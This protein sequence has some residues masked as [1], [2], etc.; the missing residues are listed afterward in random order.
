MEKQKTVAKVMRRPFLYLTFFLIAVIL[1]ADFL[2]W[3]LPFHR[4]QLSDWSN[5]PSTLEGTVKRK[6][7]SRKNERYIVEL[8][9]VHC[10]GMTR[11]TSE[12]IL[13]TTLFPSKLE[14][15]DHVVF[16][17]KLNPFEENTND[18]LF[19]PKKF[20]RSHDLTLR[21]MI[22]EENL[23]SRQSE[24][25]LSDR[26]RSRFRNHVV[27]TAES[28]LSFEDVSLIQS[29]LLA[30]DSL[31]DEE[32]RNGFRRLGLAHLLCVSGLHVGIL[33]A[34]VL[35]IMK[36]FGI[37]PRISYPLTGGILVLYAF[38]LNFPTPVLRATLMAILYLVAF[39]IREPYDMENACWFSA[40]V[41]LLFRPYQ[42]YAVGFQLSFAATL[43]IAYLYRPLRE[44]CY[45]LKALKGPIALLLAVQA[46]TF[47]LA[48]YYFNYFNPW[49]WLANL[50]FTPFFTGILWLAF[51]GVFVGFFSSAAIL[52][53]G[54]FLHLSLKMFTAFL[55]ILEEI[56]VGA[57]Y[58]ASPTPY[59]FLLYYGFLGLFFVFRRRH[60][61]DVTMAIVAILFLILLL[62]EQG[63]LYIQER[64][65]L[66]VTIIDIGQGDAILIE[67]G[68]KNVLL[69]T[70]G[71]PFSKDAIPRA[72]TVP[73]LKKRGIDRLDALFLSHYDEDHAAG[74]PAL[75]ENFRIDFCLV[76]Y[77]SESKY[78]KLLR[79][80]EIPIEI[81]VEGTEWKLA[82]H[83]SIRCLGPDGTRLP[84]ELR[85]GNVSS[86]LVLEHFD[87]KMLFT[88]DMEREQEL[89]VVGL[90]PDVDVLKVG[91][92][93][94]K[95]ST[96]KELLEASEPEIAV[97]SVGRE[98]PYGHPSEEVL[99][100]LRD[101]NIRVLRTDQSGEIILRFH[102]ESIVISDVHSR[103]GMDIM[104]ILLTL[105]FLG[106]LIF[107]GKIYSRLKEES[108]GL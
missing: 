95:T 54:F 38:L 96:G 22:R 6:M 98:N 35:F 47:P 42:L 106:I 80:S 94:S 12:K 103:K 9:R 105:P 4:S 90:L 92:H 27:K 65:D 53:P 21:T 101:R 99:S 71:S 43:S 36:L 14:P 31:L 55:H 70:G 18:G 66:T 67:A 75:M 60:K 39:Q 64:E 30:D 89:G 52:I 78:Y 102:G 48:L 3:P 20:Y 49:A 45:P 44:L 13:L 40:F 32:L 5:R 57:E 51:L 19:N 84:R 97:I 17:G 86:V 68:G 69:D 87:Q 24:P 74:V 104:Q 15:G 83:T 10:E 28:M 11:K 25:T 41:I 23:L 8:S 88:G 72:V 100:R 37:S 7:S 93:G 59:L 56:S 73:F 91:H 50:F 82:D 61:K 62:T 29:I 79:D 34:G 63:I 76:P 85:R 46:G 77:E 26:F 16:K 108:H 33:L 58:L 107:E 81:T 1:F 2:E